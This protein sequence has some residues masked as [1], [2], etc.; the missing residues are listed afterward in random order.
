MKRTLSGH[1]ID[2]FNVIG[3]ALNICQTLY[4]SCGTNHQ[5]KIFKTNQNVQIWSLK[6]LIWDILSLD[7]I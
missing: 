1:I 2:D 5:T 7:L 6:K 4:Q 3:L